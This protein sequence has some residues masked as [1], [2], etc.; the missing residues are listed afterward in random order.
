MAPYILRR[1]MLL[2]PM[3]L[4]VGIIV[5]ALVRLTPGDP[6]VVMA[7]QEASPE[8]IERVREQLGLNEP[9]A[10]QF[11]RWFGGVVRLDFGES[12]FLNQ[13]VTTALMER[14][15]P[16]LLLTLYAMTI[17]LAIAVPSGIL[18]AVRRN[19]LLDR[20]FLVLAVCGAAVPS[21]VLGILLI[22]VF[23]V[24]MR[25]LPSGG[26]FEV[27][28]DPVD[29]FRTMILPA[30]T[31]GFV[32]APFLSRVVR[33][34]LL[35]VLHEDYIRTA[36]AKGLSARTVLVRHALRN[37][38][39][40]TVTAVGLS[41]GALLGGAVVTETV[42]RLPGM[43]QLVIQSIQRRDFPVIQ[44]TVMVIAMIKILMNLLVDVVYGYLDPRVHYGS[45]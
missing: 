2:I 16:T 30:F 20:L 3:V 24:V 29:H 35:E 15:Q 26:Y 19:S 34:S 9:V 4:S 13:P 6:A 41:L 44:G 28:R 33:S 10:M 39:I 42:F 21:F 5:F 7:G 27:D 11:V 8:Q 45:S 12:F 18:A 37:A 14:A 25:I 31:L 32:I 40:P 1:L 36:R 23:A 22:L 17:A 43:G 38:L